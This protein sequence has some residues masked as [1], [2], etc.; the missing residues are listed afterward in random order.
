MADFLAVLGKIIEK[1]SNA[2]LAVRHFF[3]LGV[4]CD[5]LVEVV[6][7]VK[8]FSLLNSVSKN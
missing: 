4:C 8:D 1:R 5:V 3:F 2:F 6:M 7:Y